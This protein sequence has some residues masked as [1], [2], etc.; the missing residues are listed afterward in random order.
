MLSG[1]TQVHEND[2][3][4]SICASGPVPESPSVSQSVSI[5]MPTPIPTP[6]V[7][8]QGVFSEQRT[9]GEPAIICGLRFFSAL[10]AL[11]FHFPLSCHNAMFI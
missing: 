10:S 11:S 5:P 7:R 4:L 1:C 2:L 9:Q 3:R 6:M 8:T